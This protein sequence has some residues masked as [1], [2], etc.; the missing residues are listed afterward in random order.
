[1]ARNFKFQN[2]TRKKTLKGYKT[3]DNIS[4]E[5]ES[6]CGIEADGKFIPVNLVTAK[7]VYK[8]YV[9]QK[10]SPPTSKKLLWN[11]FNID[12]KNW[13]S[14]YL[15]PARVTLD[16]KIRMFHCKILVCALV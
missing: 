14:V 12:D 2:P 1:M 5:E 9:S 15:L 3:E 6:Q 8:F 4:N 10:F 13:S 11:K 7:L 16:T